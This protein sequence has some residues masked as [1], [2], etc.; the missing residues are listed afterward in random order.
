[1]QMLEN[2]VRDKP[3]ATASGLAVPLREFNLL[4]WFS[5]ISLLIITAVAGGLGYVSTRFVVRDSVQRDAMLTAQ[6]IQAMAQA[7]VRHSQLPPGTTMGELLDPRLD[8]QH[9]QFTPALAESTRVEFLDHV[10]H[11]PDTLLANV[12]ARDRTIVWS[13]NVEL[14]GK[15]IE[16]DG[17]LDRAFRSRKAV[18]ASYH[19][20]EEDREEQK[21]QR[22]PRYLFIENYIPLFDSQGEQVLAMVEIYKE[23][24]DL[25]R[26]IQRGYVLIWASTLVGGALIYFGLFWIVRRAAQMLHLQQDRLVA[27]E[28]YVALGEMSSAVAHSLRNPLANIRSSAELAQETANVAAQKNITDII[29]Q[30][31]RMS[32][33]VRDLLVSL[34]P[35]SD[36][37]EAV[38]LVAAIEDTHLAFAQQIERNGVRFHF[39]GPD[40][41]WVASQPL[42]LTQILNSLF[43]NALEAMPC[44]GMLNAHVNVQG[45]LR[46]EFVLTDTGKGMSQQQERMV[47]KPFFTTKQGGLGIGLALVKRIMERFGG[48]VSLSSREEEGTRVSLT[49]NI[50]AGGDHGAQHPG[51]R[52]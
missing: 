6:F 14:I 46:A 33:W 15:R 41:Q 2:E 34:R 26:R 49:F 25:V 13:T 12:Y 21:F 4:R 38:D 17:D 24:Q 22:E 18:S 29:S 47:F 3:G 1:M 10:E 37:P 28:T 42:Q 31:D 50:A 44:G 39:E 40:V 19:K 8:L 32:R 30:V 11:L 45:G 20:A 52:G 16:A 5:V 35:T 51:S 9:L 27:S 7:E 43:S 23:P 36:E 48:S